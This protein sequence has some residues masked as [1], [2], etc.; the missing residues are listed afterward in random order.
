MMNA[1]VPEL[2]VKVV[3]LEIYCLKYCK[4]ILIF[5]QLFFLTVS[6][7]SFNLCCSQKN[8]DSLVCKMIIKL[9]TRSRLLYELRYKA[10]ICKIFG[11]KILSKYHRLSWKLLIFSKTLNT[12]WSYENVLTLNFFNSLCFGFV[13]QWLTRGMFGIPFWKQSLFMQFWS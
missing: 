4:L 10:E 6:L 2:R 13:H 8:T 5:W 11:V 1:T 9:T 12:V 3:L 7:L